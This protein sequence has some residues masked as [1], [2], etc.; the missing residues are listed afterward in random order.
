MSAAFSATWLRSTPSKN[1]HVLR[2]S[3]LAAVISAARVIQS[4]KL[5]GSRP[6]ES[7]TPV[8]IDWAKRVRRVSEAGLRR[9]PATP[10]CPSASLMKSCCGAI[11][12]GDEAARRRRRL[13]EGLYVVVVVLVTFCSIT[14]LGYLSF[15]IRWCRAVTPR[16][17]CRC[18]RGW[19]GRD[20]T[21]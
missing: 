7:K 6:E 9:M 14:F 12:V 4:T 17:C 18:T 21:S 13:V 15:L 8:L 20:T 5:S 11:V 3:C 2:T 1:G 19:C 10:S 16:W